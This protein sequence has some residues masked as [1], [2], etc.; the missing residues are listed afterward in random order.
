MCGI[1]GVV[2]NSIGFQE[3]LLFQQLLFFN[4]LRGRDG[5]GVLV[6]E[7]PNAKTKKKIA[8]GDKLRLRGLKAATTPDFF[9]ENKS[10]DKSMALSPSKRALIGHTRSATIGE[11]SDANCHPFVYDK[12][13]GV[14]NGTIRKHQFPSEFDCETDS[15]SLIMMMNEQG[16]IPALEEILGYDDAPFALVYVDLTNSTLNMLRSK[17]GEGSR[18]QRPLALIRSKDGKSLIFTSDYRMLDWAGEYVDYAYQANTEPVEFKPNIL[19]SFDLLADDPVASLS[20]KTLTPKPKP[21]FHYTK[22]DDTH[23]VGSKVVV[24]W[25][26]FWPLKT[27]EDEQSE[28]AE[29]DMYESPFGRKISQAEFKRHISKGCTC[30]GDVIDADKFDIDKRI[31]WANFGAGWEAICEDCKDVDWIK[32]EFPR[33]VWNASLEK[34]EFHRPATDNAQ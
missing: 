7:E 33:W 17:S 14:V 31:G 28:P 12:I 23:H 32:N 15:E 8:N 5:T 25:R 29:P 4:T 20:T 27:H 13:A 9:L 18:D 34:F 16:A 19:V 1:C 10:V 3:K 11:I 24:P 21:K 6:V 2:S 30:C 26:S 22:Y